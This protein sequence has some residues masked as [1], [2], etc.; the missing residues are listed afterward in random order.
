M[1]MRLNHIDHV[2][3]NVNDL[4][5]AKAFFI[6]FGLEVEAEWR[7]EG[8]WLD[9]IVGLD[10]VRTEAIMLLLPDGQTKLELVKYVAPADES[11]LQPALAN[12]HGIRH[13]AIQV[14][15]LEAVVARLKDKGM[16]VFGD[17]YNY[18]DTF[19]LVYCRGPEGII[20]ELAEALK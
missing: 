8:A 19:K 15:D 11:G 5:A 9:Q 7:A 3:I 13:I 12:A 10:G 1:H 18:E 2:G 6:E 14:D 17:I 20:L 16:D 4:A